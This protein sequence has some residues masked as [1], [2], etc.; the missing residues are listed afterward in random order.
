[1]KKFHMSSCKKLLLCAVLIVPTLLSSVLG[2]NVA[3]ASGETIVAS[4]VTGDASGAIDITTV[5]INGTGNDDVPVRLHVSSGTLGMSATPGVTFN[6]GLSG[7]TLEFHGHRNDVNTALQSLTYTRNS[8]TGTDTLEISLVDPGDVFFPDNGHLYQ[9]ISTPLTW[10]AAQPDA[11]SRTKYGAQ[12]YLATITSANE[13]AFIAARLNEPG[14]IGASDA[15]TEGDWKWVTG[16]ESGTSFWSGS[17]SGNGGVP[18]GGQYSNWNSGEPNN[19]SNEDCAQFLSGGSGYWNDLR[20]NAPT[21]AYVVEYGAPGNLPNVESDEITIT[22]ALEP[23]AP[24]GVSATAGIESAQVSF[25]AP[26]NNAS[27]I[28]GYT[29]TSSPGGIEATGSTSPITVT[30][31]TAGTVYTFAVVAT[32]A[33]G[34]SNPSGA[35]N[36]VTPTSAPSWED[37]LTDMPRVDVP[38]SDSISASGYP[39]VSYEITGGALPAGLVLDENTGE[40]TGTPT[41]AG[42]YEF[43]VTVSNGVGTDLVKT[44]SGQVAS[45]PAVDLN[46]EFQVGNYLSEDLSVMISG[47]GLLP[48][49]EYS[50]VVESSPRTIARGTITGSG[51][52]SARTYIPRDIGAGSHSITLYATSATGRALSDVAYFRVNNSGRIIAVSET[53]AIGDELPLTGLQ[54]WGLVVVALLSVMVGFALTKR[55]VFRNVL[56]LSG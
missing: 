9:I 37:D 28:T 31:L 16:P 35:S 40:I 23:N 42:S 29:V 47:A 46:L 17:H 13:N 21:L 27:P 25:T 43:E 12:G 49:S 36:S 20:C 26:A 11:A 10:V 22:A 19:S 48:G 33:I 51:S 45:A 8:G 24:T 54:M 1:M 30:G 6:S 50:V 52:F 4:N 18:V 38:F 34:D 56:P 44:F 5:S 32:N 15:A 53:S 14:W 2:A 7:A 3:G 41:L 55:H 39:A